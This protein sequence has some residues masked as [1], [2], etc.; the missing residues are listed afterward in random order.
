MSKQTLEDCK[1]NST[2]NRLTLGSQVANSDVETV[3]QVSWVSFL[4]LQKKKFLNQ[5]LQGTKTNQQTTCSLQA[6]AQEGTPQ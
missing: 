6:K 2:E 3:S 1:S 4:N 5:K